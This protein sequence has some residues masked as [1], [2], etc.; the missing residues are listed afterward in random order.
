MKY[1]QNF[2]VFE[3]VNEDIISEILSHDGW[4]DI[5]PN[6]TY[7]YR[8]RN[9]ITDKC[10]VHL[11]VFYESDTLWVG[12]S[13][14]GYDSAYGLGK[15]GGISISGLEQKIS[16]YNQMMNVCHFLSR[17]FE[18]EP[19]KAIL[20]FIDNVFI[21]I[22][23]IAELFD[24][25]WGYLEEV[26]SKNGDLLYIEFGNFPPRHASDKLGYGISWE[27][28][29]DFEEIKKE[30]EENKDKLEIKLSSYNVNM[31]NHVFDDGRKFVD[32]VI[33]DIEID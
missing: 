28:K 1:L 10:V 15:Y 33:S 22:S 17:R 23:D 27:Y 16:D 3:Q 20:D 31:F 26:K 11:N 29:C 7:Q 13:K 4:V 5:G 21:D 14:P 8:L 6:D 18:S 9:K 25:S 24:K 2:K 12:M 19:D 32:I 30:F